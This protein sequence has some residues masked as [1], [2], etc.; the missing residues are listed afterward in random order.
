MRN[1]KL[2]STV[3]ISGFVVMAFEIIGSRV[4]APFLGTS[5]FVWV[6]I[7]GIILL[8]MSVGYYLGGRWADKSP[9]LKRLS[10]FLFGAALGIAITNIL[11]N[12]A[13]AILGSLAFPLI[14]KSSLASVALFSF[15]AFCLAAIFPYALKLILNNIED[16]GKLS[17]RIYAISTIGSLLGTFL[18]ATILIPLLGTDMILWILSAIL[19]VLGFIVGSFY[20]WKQGVLMIPILIGN[21]WFIS[22]DKTIIDLDSE[23]NR[24][25]IYDGIAQGKPTRYLALNGHV[26]SGMWVNDPI[27]GQLYPYS[28]YFRLAMHLNPDFQDVL[29]LGAGAYTF[30]KLFQSIWPERRLD[31][32]EIDP[33]LTKVSE[34]HFAWEASTNTHIVHMDARSYLN[35]CKKTYDIIISDVFTSPLEV[36]FQLTTFETYKRHQ[37][38]LNKDGV[39]ILNVLGNADGQYSR[40][41]KSQYAVAKLVFL[42]VKLFEV[43]DEYDLPIKNNMLIAMNSEFDPNFQSNDST[44]QHM[45]SQLKEVTIDESTPI[46][47]D[48]YAPANWLLWD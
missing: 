34:T 20:N 31:I 40:F 7:I 24:I 18:S 35:Q 44:I 26:N 4:L 21:L 11:K 39:L 28:D 14:V 47:T 33:V 3:F 12:K 27:A 48:N 15:P 36:P 23:Y 25:W 10:Y 9:T 42:H 38:L 17:G 13:L 46:L 32:V 5:T 6:S 1:T 41:L 43:Y 30:P 2:F 8:A 22:R 37:A 19:L 29:M 16:A 45:L